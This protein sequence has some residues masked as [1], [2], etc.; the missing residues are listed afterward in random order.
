[1]DRMSIQ[2]IN[3]ISIINMFTGKKVL[4]IEEP[5]TDSLNIAV[6]VIN[7]YCDNLET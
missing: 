5:Y 6:D 3:K 1:M 2:K 7:D 4:E